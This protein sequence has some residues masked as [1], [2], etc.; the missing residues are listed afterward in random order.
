MLHHPLKQQIIATQ[1]SS[2]F[3]QNLGI[4]FIPEVMEEI[5]VAVEDILSAF[6]FIKEFYDLP[7][8]ISCLERNEHKIPHDLYMKIWQN[9]RL[10]MRRSTR[11][12]LR[13]RS[14]NS[15]DKKLLARYLKEKTTI[16][17]LLPKLATGQP[18]K[19]YSKMIKK[20][21]AF[22]LSKEDRELL[23]IPLL[24]FS[25]LNIIDSAINYKADVKDI[26]AVHFLVFDKM[27]TD[28]LRIATS[29]NNFS[30]R[31]SVISRFKVKGDI[32][33]LQ[34]DLTGI[35]YSNCY[36]K[37][38]KKCQYNIEDRHADLLQSWQK[39]ALLLQPD[40]RL[41]FEV[42]F[43]MIS[44]LKRIKSELEDYYTVLKN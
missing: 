1:L 8:I 2:D 23:S 36:E 5:D 10:L 24:E 26:T 25:A 17:E 16:Q 40:A 19:L 29:Y 12:L 34:R 22:S 37:N 18:K 39:Y 27:K 3:V 21:D 44:E 41:D 32:D 43:V 13:N 7:A 15:T 6:L 38:I 28:M 9:L 20:L 14:I 11:W 42:I 35:F 30:S 4:T 31:W 33:S